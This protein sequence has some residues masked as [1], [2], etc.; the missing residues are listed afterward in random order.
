[1][2]SDNLFNLPVQNFRDIAWIDNNSYFCLCDDSRDISIYRGDPDTA[3]CYGIELRVDTDSCDV[4]ECGRIEVHTVEV[5]SFEGSFSVSG[6]YD[7]GMKLPLFDNYLYTW[8]DQLSLSSTGRFIVYYVKDILEG[9]PDAII[10]AERS[11]GDVFRLASVSWKAV[12]QDNEDD[13]QQL[14]SFNESSNHLISMNPQAEECTIYNVSC[15]SQ[16]EI[17]KLNAFYNESFQNG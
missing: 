16:V 15:V 17:N 12:C 13:Y 11:T 8:P 1:M 7:N 2:D 5:D 6:S 3:Y 9:I 14:I 10:L 4:V